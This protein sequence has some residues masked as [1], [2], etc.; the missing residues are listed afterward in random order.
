MFVC[1]ECGQRYER[2][3]Y[4][5]VHGQ[6]LTE[7]DDPLLGTDLGRY[8]L[9]SLIGEGGMGR[10]YL[11]VQPVIGSRVAVK[12]LAEQ[13]AE[14]QELV[15]RFFAEAR[16]VNLIKH[17]CI[18]SVLDLAKLDDG[19]PY[20]VMEYVAGST[21]TGLIAGGPLPI[22][23]VSRVMQEVLSALGAA[24]AIGIV[25][26]DLKPE[27][28]FSS[29]TRRSQGGARSACDRGR[30]RQMPSQGSRRAVSQRRRPRRSPRRARNRRQPRRHTIRRRGG[31]RLRVD[32]HDRP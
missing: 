13:C 32:F 10:V 7:S 28:I 21:L 20:I 4:C 17:E 14:N 30:D 29:A 5:A 11:A 24:H 25:H 15:E 31:V 27:N 23:G 3:G 19:R 8:R 12:V 16:S 9:A 1:G 26:R 2:A 22:G 18:V 6:P